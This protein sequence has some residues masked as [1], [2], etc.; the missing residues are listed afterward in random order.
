METR[1]YTYLFSFRL[2]VFEVAGSRSPVPL[3]AK[4]QSSLFSVLFSE[5]RARIS[6][7]VSADSKLQMHRM[8]TLQKRS[9]SNHTNLTVTVCSDGFWL[10]FLWRPHPNKSFHLFFFQKSRTLWDIVW[11]AD[12]PERC[13]IVW[14]PSLVSNNRTRENIGVGELRTLAFPDIRPS[15]LQLTWPVFSPTEMY[16]TVRSFFL[17]PR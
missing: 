1:V 11:L 13:F 14:N 2:N 7:S 10:Y 8:A 12:Y 4:L 5:V 9:L 15:L 6:Y 3:F 16:R 17:P